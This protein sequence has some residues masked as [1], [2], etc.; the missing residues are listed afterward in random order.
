MWYFFKTF[1]ALIN[2]GTTQPLYIP[3]WVQRWY[4]IG[5]IQ[6]DTVDHLLW[7]W[8][9]L[10]W[11][12]KFW[13]VYEPWGKGHKALRRLVSLMNELPTVH[14]TLKILNTCGIYNVDCSR[15][16][17]H[18]QTQKDKYKK[19]KKKIDVKKTKTKKP[20]RQKVLH[21]N[22]QAPDTACAVPNTCLVQSQDGANAW[23][24]FPHFF[25]KALVR[26]RHNRMLN[27]M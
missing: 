8:K 13:S 21:L 2:S 19:K 24:L 6:L 23:Q 27:M 17:L 5:S 7:I 1:P 14:L 3:C 11:N 10:I 22:I 25:G 4:T 20:V 12:Y 9:R 16:I 15:L 18:L 26:F